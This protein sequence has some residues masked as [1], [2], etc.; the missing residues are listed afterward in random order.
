MREERER[1]K[2][3]EKEKEKEAEKP[4]EVNTTLTQEI[5]F[6]F[7]IITDHIE[8]DNNEKKKLHSPS[9]SSEDTNA[10]TNSTEGNEFEHMEITQQQQ[11]INKISQPKKK[12]QKKEK[13]EEK[14]GNTQSKSKSR[15]RSNSRAPKS[16]LAIKTHTIDAS[17]HIKSNKKKYILSFD[18]LVMLLEEAHSCEDIK[19]LA[20]NYTKNLKE[21]A[22]MLEVAKELMLNTGMKNYIKS[23]IRQIKS[24]ESEDESGD[25]SSDD[26]DT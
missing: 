19:G 4:G 21:L 15:S 23:I 3:K 16:A 12:R 11:K 2:E 14:N 6:S 22:H 24:T 20:K 7:P 25:Y 26:T 10:T 1:E 5:A 8:S 9:T 17:N 18:E 13:R